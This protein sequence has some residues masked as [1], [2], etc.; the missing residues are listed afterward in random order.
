MYLIPRSAYSSAGYVKLDS[1]VAGHSDYAV[2]T[3]IKRHTAFES[4]RHCMTSGL[5]E[6]VALRFSFALANAARI[7]YAVIPAV[8]EC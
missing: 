2:A 7:D 4:M 5:P 1:I 6:S 3:A 8:L